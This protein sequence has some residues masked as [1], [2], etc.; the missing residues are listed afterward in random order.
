MVKRTGPTNPLLKRTIIAFERKKT[1]FHRRIA[2]LLSKPTRKRV[3]VNVWKLNKLCKDGE[4]VVVPG[5][6][7]G[8]GKLRKKLVVY[9]WRFS[10]GARKKIIEAGGEARRIEELLESE[11]KPRIIV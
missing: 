6:V 11:E 10:E 2:E 8:D 3:E 9:A 1:P 4:H 7:L 5:V